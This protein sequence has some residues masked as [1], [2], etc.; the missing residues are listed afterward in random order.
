MFTKTSRSLGL[1]G[2]L[3]ASAAVLLAGAGT[4]HAYPMQFPARASSLPDNGYFVTN[5]H[6]AKYV[7]KGGTTWA[8]DIHVQRYVN[9]QWQR[10]APG[11]TTLAED[12]SFGTPLYSATDG[13]VIACWRGLPDSP[14]PT[15]NICEDGCPAGHTAGGNH[16]LIVTPEG[17]HVVYYAHLADSIPASLCPI[18]DADG[19]IDDMAVVGCPGLSG[20]RN[21]TRLDLLLGADNLPVVKKGD[22]I[23]DLGHSGNSWAPHLHLQVNP[24]SFDDAVDPNPCQG[25][26]EEIEY[27]ETWQ[28]PRTPGV[29]ASA[30][31]WAA[32]NHQPL[33]VTPAT[34]D[35]LV[36]PDPVGARK[37]DLVLGSGNS[38]D[39]ETDV[40]G[41]LTAYR[42]DDGQLRLT[43]FRIGTGNVGDELLGDLVVQANR[44]EGGV[45]AL[46]L[47]KLPVSEREYALAIRGNNGRLKVIPY[48]VNYAFGTITR[49]PGD[50][51]DG[52]IT[53][54]A[55]VPSPSHS[56]L[57]VAV[58]EDNGTLKVIDY[59][60]AAGTLAI[61]RPGSAGSGGQQIV[62]LAITATKGQFN[63][64]VTAEVATNT[65]S[66]T[67]RSFSVSAGADVVAQHTVVAAPGPATQISLATVE[68]LLFPGM[69]AVA[70]TMRDAATGNLRIQ[71]WSVSPTGSL[72]LQDE[73]T[74]GGV[75]AIDVA[76][77]GGRDV[78]VGVRANSGNLWQLSWATDWGADNLRRTGTRTAGAIS[79]LDLAAF[80]GTPGI[81]A[82]PRY[83]HLLTGVRTSD[84]DLKVLS[85]AINFAPWY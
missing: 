52:P 12:H 82:H 85:N 2:S 68:G 69:A 48:H 36:W 24:F 37:Q 28:Q 35:F 55:A 23:G 77:V 6:G 8:Q 66:V 40:E 38:L 4:A 81:N 63:G 18:V 51:E 9:G 32:L 30:Y 19:L 65:A 41:G 44:N 31:A 1:P 78:V 13:V 20:F 72:T 67:L 70:V 29:D 54:L 74:A 49:M 7:A 50:R 34:G 10:R 27:V 53:H 45:A 75:G 84:G 73:R 42:T 43:S 11:A 33:P 21:S 14:N 59:V 58:R 3:V 56:G 46:D 61:T 80:Y 16:I 60:A 79:G 76:A 22:Y 26:S 64:V 39:V 25:V 5:G 17:D 47:V 71:T 57:V 62:D 83:R 15:Q